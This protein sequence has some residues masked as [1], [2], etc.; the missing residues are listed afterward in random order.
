MQDAVLD[1]VEAALETIVAASADLAPCS[2]SAL[3]C[4]HRDRV[5]N[6]AVVDAARSLLGVAPEGVPADLPGVLRAPAGRGGRRPSR[7]DR[8]RGPERPVRPRPALRGLRRPR[9]RGPC[10]DLRG[11]LGADP[12]ELG[13]RARGRDRAPEPLRQPDHRRPRGGPHAPLPGP[14]LALPVRI[15]LRGGRRGRVDHGP[16]VGRA[17]GHPRE[18]R[19]PRRLRALPDGDRR[20]VA[21][22]DLDL[23]RQERMRMGTFDDNRRT[24]AARTG[25]FRRSPSRSARPPATSACGAGW[26]ASRSSPPTRRGSSWTAT[27]PTTSRS[28]AS[29]AA[30]GHR[31]PEGRHRRLAAGS[32]PRTR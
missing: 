13:G 23:L 8:R 5:F 21:D 11:P 15:R 14:V 31:R 27:R 29:P 17:D 12:A 16:V 22:V 9:A 19:A 7:R 24:H 18:R 26:S 20:S 10:G 1:G 32:T 25:A 3:R 30:V 28:R 4:A 6:C 2:R